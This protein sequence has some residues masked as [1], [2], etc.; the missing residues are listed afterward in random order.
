[1]LTNE[2]LVE[3]Q[4]RIMEV[5]DKLNRVLGFNMS[6]P[7]FYFDV[8]STSAGLAK[9]KTMSVHFNKKLALNHWKEF[10]ENT[11]P[12]EVCHVAIWHWAKV[13]KDKVPPPHGVKW[14][15]FMRAVGC[16]PTRTHSFDVSEIK[17]KTKKYLYQC[18]CEKPIEVSPVVHKKIESGAIYTCKKCNQK[19]RGGNLKMSERMSQFFK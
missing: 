16:V 10:I 7:K 12:H 8:N 15:S 1:M 6:Y 4:N 17:R 19:L 5:V 11:I 2:K 18:A 3:T 13:L 14:K 9:S